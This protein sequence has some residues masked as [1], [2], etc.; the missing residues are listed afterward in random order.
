MESKGKERSSSGK[1][2]VNFIK[3]LW[4]VTREMGNCPDGYDRLFA[5]I[6]SEG[7]SGV[8]TPVSVV[9]DKEKFVAALAKHGLVY[10]AMI[11]TCTFDKKQSSKLE[12]RLS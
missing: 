11:N 2:G 6:K 12:V 1:I 5:R 10:V 4:G 3:T 8:E 9:E 7:F